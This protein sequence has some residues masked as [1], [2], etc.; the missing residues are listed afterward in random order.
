MKNIYLFTIALSVL[1]LTSCDEVTNP[2]PDVLD[3]GSTIV[4]DD[5]IT[6]DSLSLE[7]LT[8]EKYEGNPTTKRNLLI[9]EFTG[10]QCTACPDGSRILLNLDTVYGEQVTPVS[11]HAGNFAEP[12][13]DTTDVYG[14]DL[15][16]NPEGEIIKNTFNPS[17]TFPR[18][19]VSRLTTLSEG[20]DNWRRTIDAHKDDAPTA[21]IDLDVWYA[22][23]EEYIRVIIDY[24]FLFNSNEPHDLQVYLVEDNIV[25]WQLDNGVLKSDYNHKYVMRRAVNGAWGSTALPSVVGDLHHK[26]YVLIKDKKWKRKNMKVVVYIAN[27]DSREILQTSQVKLK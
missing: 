14:I 11:I 3:D 27:R 10:I 24:E 18:G 15:R 16:S 8:W 13:P 6:L 23:N 17:N 19:I 20:K 5:G 4:F 7:Q 21:I 26:E 22:P 25:G 9:E 1:V 2:Y 12:N